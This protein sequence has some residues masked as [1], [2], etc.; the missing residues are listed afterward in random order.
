M[1]ELQFRDIAA[2][3][4]G[5]SVGEMT[6]LI[7]PAVLRAARLVPGQGVLDIAAG[8]GLAAEATLL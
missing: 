5:R 6:R 7:V 1:S 2:A 8:T 3:G 4:Y